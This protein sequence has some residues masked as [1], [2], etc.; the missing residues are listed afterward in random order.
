M[1]K[2]Y[3]PFVNYTTMKKYI[4]LLIILFIF[5]LISFANEEPEKVSPTLNVELE[6]PVQRALI[7]GKPHFNVSVELDAGRYGGVKILVK[8]PQTGKKIYKKNFK[9]SY[10]YAFSDGTI[11][12]GKGNALT[13]LTLVKSIGGFY[14]MEVREKGLY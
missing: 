13:Q 4:I 1:D 2:I 11:Q 14:L 9:N 5:P 7:E 8:D 6:R 12:I 3:K 10:L